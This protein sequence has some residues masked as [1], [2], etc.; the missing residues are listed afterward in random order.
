MILGGVILNKYKVVYLVYF[1]FLLSWIF[2]FTRPLWDKLDY[3]VFKFL[4]HYLLLTPTMQQFWSYLNSR[5][6]DIVFEVTV[7]SFYLISLIFAKKGERLIKVY[8]VLFLTATIFLTQ[9][10][11]NYYLLNKILMMKRFS[12]SVVIGVDVNIEALYPIWNNKAISHTSFP[13]DHVTT[14]L[15][16]VY[17]VN[18]HCLKL[19]GNFMYPLAVLLSLPRLTAGAHWFTD[20]LMGACGIALAVLAILHFTNIEER[21]LF[22]RKVGKNKLDKVKCQV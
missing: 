6:T 9:F 18:K 7:V 16:C 3:I 5:Y 13:A 20:V 12:P 11:F 4:H 1:L 22:L 15:L 8:Q 21:L 19:F 14:I 10:A 2:P 17:F